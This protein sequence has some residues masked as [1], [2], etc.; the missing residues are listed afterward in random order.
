MRYLAIEQ[1]V[2]G[3]TPAQMKPWLQ[4]EAHA[5]WRLQQADALRE[6]WFTTPDRRAVLL[7]ECADELAAQ[8]ALNSLPLVRERCIRFEV[9]AL[10]PYDGLARILQ[11]PE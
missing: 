8:A 3:V 11:N 1:D 6:I 10:R 7:L 9:L 2:D 5:V 4:E